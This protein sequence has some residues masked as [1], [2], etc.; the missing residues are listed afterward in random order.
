M[1]KNLLA[2]AVLGAIAG[3][4]Q[5]Q[6]TVYGSYD[7]GLRRLTNADAAG[8]SNLTMSSGGTYNS[9]RIGFSGVEDLGDGLQTIFNLETGFDSGDGSLKEGALFGRHAIVGL[10]GSWG[11]VVLG[12][13]YTVAMQTVASYDP[14]HYH[15][16]GIIPVIKNTT[17]VR[18]SNAIQYTGNFG[19]VTARAEYALGEVPGST[20]NGAAQAVGA[21]YSANGLT[22]GA[23]YTQKK[24]AN[25]DEKH[26]TLGGEYS[27]GPVRFDLGYANDKQATA[28]VD[29]TR[30]DAWGGVAYRVSPAVGLTAAYY[31][32][33]SS[34]GGV[35]GTQKQ[36]I[37]GATYALSKRTNFYSEIDSTRYSGIS[38]P[39]GQTHQT[40]F[41]AGINHLF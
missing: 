20:S 26:Y 31:D 9:N 34:A 39:S 32:V 19:A 25:F 21:V 12:R 22:L 28:T 13:E 40:G 16:T 37:V 15:Y 4:A 38:T 30:K 27:V 3:A 11:K 17:G 29:S 2:I 33:K 7:G 6:V 35:D 23:A 18:N 24:P 8:N 36:F 5:A 1:K 41:S 10:K 14:F